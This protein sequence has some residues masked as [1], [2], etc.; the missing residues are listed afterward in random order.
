M[1]IFSPKYPYPKDDP[2]LRHITV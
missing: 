1:S 2:Q